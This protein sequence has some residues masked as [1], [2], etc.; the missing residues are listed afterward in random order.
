MHTFFTK[1][2]NTFS[3]PSRP[4]FTGSSIIYEERG[5]NG[6]EIDDKK[7][8]S[9]QQGRPNTPVPTRGTPF[10]LPYL[11]TSSA[12]STSLP[13]RDP[14][15]VFRCVPTPTSTSGTYQGLRVLYGS[16]PRSSVSGP[17]YT[18][19]PLDRIL[20][21]G[22]TPGRETGRLTRIGGPKHGP[23]LLPSGG[24]PR[25]GCGVLSPPVGPWFSSWV[26][27]HGSG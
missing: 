4:H 27:D 1:G 8:R 26:P 15:P 2:T 7:E 24:T 10:H 20:G 18:V 23:D 25:L 19:L 14:P 11:H 3:D 16:S 12:T 5:N 13:A 6:D 9:K 21:G 17:E 22:T